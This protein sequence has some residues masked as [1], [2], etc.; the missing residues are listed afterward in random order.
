MAWQHMEPEGCS[1]I[2][3]PK[4]QHEQGRHGANTAVASSNYFEGV[5]TFF[6]L[7]RNTL[8]AELHNRCHDHE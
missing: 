1:S 8:F 2:A 7:I 4:Q 3:T 6:F 5:S